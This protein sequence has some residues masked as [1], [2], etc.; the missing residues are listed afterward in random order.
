AVGDVLEYAITVTNTGNVTLENIEVEDALTGLNETI[1]NLAP[2]GTETFP[3]THTITQSDLDNGSVLNVATANGEDPNGNNVDP[4]DPT[5]GEEETPAIQEPSFTILKE[6]ISVNGDASITSYNAVG[7][8]LEYAITVTN[9]GNVTITDVVVD[10]PLIE[11]ITN[12]SFGTLAPGD[13]IV[14]NGN[15]TI[16]N[17]DLVS[18]AVT[19]IATVSGKDP[20]D[21]NV[22]EEDTITINSI[23]NIIIANDNEFGPINGADGGTTPSVL[24]NDTLNG[25]PVDP[26]DVNLTLV[27]GDPELTL[28]P[29][30]SIAVDPN[31]P[32]GNYTLEYSICEI[33]N[34]TNCETA[35]VTV[36]VVPAPIVANDDEFGPINGT[37]GGT[38][39]SVLENDT[40]NG[41]PVDPADVNLTLVGGD[42][43]LTLNPDGSIAVDP[44]TPAG[45]YTLEY[46]ICEIL[47]PTN[48]ETATVTV[49]VV[50]APIVAND[51][52]FGPINGTDGGTTPS[53]LE[54]DTLNGEPVDPADV[55]LTL[56]DGD[57]ELTLNPD[58][59]ITVGPNTPAG[60]YTLEYS[61]CEILNPTN[62]ET[63]TVTVTVVPAPIVAND[64]EFGPINGIDGGTT[65][66]VLEN[67][68]LNGEPVDPADVILTLVEGD[69]ELTL[70]PDGSITVAPDA[71]N[72]TYTWTYQICDVLNP[73]NCSTA[74][75]IIVVDGNTIEVIDDEFLAN[76]DTPIVLDVLS[77]DLS[78]LPIDPATLAIVSNTTNGTLVI[79]SDGTITYT[80]EEGFSGVDTFVYEVCDSS[81]PTPSCSQATVTITVRPI[82]VDLEKIV[83]V[84]TAAPGDILNYTLI[85][86]NRSEF[87]LTN[88]R[89]EDLLPDEL[90]F[91]SS[92][93]DTSGDLFWD[94]AEIGIGETLEI[95]LNAMV[96]EEG[97]IVNRVIFGRRGFV[98]EASAPTV[99]S[100]KIIDLAITKTS[101][102]VAIW[103]GDEFEYNIIVSNIGGTDATEV[104]IEDALPAGVRFVSQSF[105]STDSSIE[106]NFS[107]QT[108]TLRWLVSDFRSDVVIN[109]R[110]RV[111]AEALSESNEQTITNMV[112]VTGAEQ[113]SNLDNNSDND[114]N[115]I[116]PFFIPNVITPD[117]DGKND[118][119]EI[120]GLDKFDSNNIVILNRYGDH[121]F[122]A[123]D[124]QNDWSSENLP[125]S[126]YFYVLKAV[127]ASGRE[128]I[129]KG[130]IQVIKD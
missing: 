74:T 38:T 50:P 46:S 110:L 108:G 57:P 116:R 9:T 83:N 97:E 130:W 39:P 102:E 123:D 120:K 64:D 54:N 5:E 47:N 106:I 49:T 78:D 80:P 1:A 96:L 76:E 115:R 23:P 89:V 91:M 51:D 55:I 68:T 99:I 8:V 66:S 6:L 111:V 118:R 29:D 61:I 109:I 11:S 26:A 44:N 13:N 87:V 7:D 114:V 19:N 72:G 24:E 77:N 16:S 59:S 18:G 35:T 101:N 125:A 15:Y 73:T 94:F 84:E 41:E 105:E 124:Y 36:T 20:N 117:D 21:N 33:L 85:F 12:V 3:T 17:E 75:V 119:F 71:S 79:N 95:Q 53:V 129:F 4:E 2:A 90:M 42:P 92:S 82:L 122:E 98:M 58:G 113:D 81:S 100:E 104:L 52:E 70:N 48:C 28:N 30:G 60:D 34:P 103:E 63:A 62:C 107:Q 32:A 45:D 22:F 25:E 14:V 69:P 10:D 27:G 127:D 37:D 56:V 126:T 67:D 43:E 65:P 40:L 88:A 31:T 93:L 128:H 86:T 112:S 121:V